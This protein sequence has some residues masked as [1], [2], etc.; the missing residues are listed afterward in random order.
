[1]AKVKEKWST[2]KF[3]VFVLSFIFF[4]PMSHTISVLN[5]SSACYFLNASN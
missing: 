2:V 3:N 5:K 1:M 4:V